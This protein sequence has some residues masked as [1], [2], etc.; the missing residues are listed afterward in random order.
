MADQEH[1]TFVV[2]FDDPAATLGRVGGKGASLA[3]M[4]SAGLPVPPGFYVATAAYERF[5]GAHGLRER[6]LAAAGGASPDDPAAL[7]AAAQSIAALFAQHTIPADVADPIRAAYAALGGQ[8]VAVRSS[9][10]AEDLPTMSFAGQQDTFLNISGAEPVLDAIK[11]CWASLWTARA[12]GYRARQGVAHADVSLAVVVQA[13]VPAEAAGILFTANPIDGAAGQALI[14]AAWGLGEAVVGGQVTPDTFVVDK[15]SGALLSQQVS[16]KDV[17]TV[18]AG[19]GTREQPVPPEQRA[20]PALGAGQA[21]ELAS[22]GARIEQLYGQPMDIE[23]ALSQGRFFILQARPITGVRAP[24]QPAEEWNDSLRGDYLWTSTNLGEAV[25]DV[26]TPCAWS[27]IRIFIADTMP[28]PDIGEHQLVGNIGGR[29]YMNLS[30]LAAVGAAFG[31]SG[32]RFAEAN[33]QALGRLPEGVGIPPLAVSRWRVLRVMLPVALR[34]RRRIGANQ[35]RLPE[36]LAAA[37][38]R[39]E[40]LRARIGAAASPGD[41]V[42]LWHAEVLPFFRECSDMLAAGA[43][44]DGSVIVWARRELN[45]LVGEADANALLS[46]LHSSNSRLESLGP[47]VGLAQLARG[48][49]DRASYARQYGHRGPHEFE[50]SLPRPAE[51]PGWIDAQLAGLRAAPLTANELLA[52]QQG[53]QSGAWARFEQRYPGKARAMRRRIGSAAEA[54]RLREAARSE[55]VR[56]FWAL[57]AFAQRAG[58]LSGLGDDIFFLRID[59]ILAVLGGERA[60]VAH[61]P[62]RQAAYRRYAALPPY[63]VLIRGHFDPFAWAASPQRRG[64]VFDARGAAAPPRQAISGF[65]GAAGV[66]EGRA[67]VLAA[68]EE[69]AQLQPGEILVTTVTNVGWTPLFPRAAAVVTDVGAPLSHAAI[70]A[71]ELGIPAVVGCGNATM[72]LHTGDRVRVDGGRGVVELLEAA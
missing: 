40:A 24:T 10:T 5:V 37:P 32:K 59:E 69:G 4:A 7:E 39:C 27:L 63:P 11:R 19:E 3:R 66:V 51:D 23:W 17:M 13:L 57:R 42:A 68:A 20:R 47:L 70:V 30:V 26:M 56:S 48:E 61:I 22:L 65:P 64:D 36:F 44:S 53:A 2:A 21:A 33:E 41:L 28:V 43:R 52:R 72:R 9:A 6:V 54:F 34:F 12:I 45:K 38:A 58:A 60:A 14:N 35:R 62:A 1:T 50:V 18:L 16:A 55:V 29:F 49:I 67:R 46:G 71:R 31:I 8:P 15:A 25:P